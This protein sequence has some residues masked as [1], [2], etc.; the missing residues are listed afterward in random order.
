MGV[1]FI[2]YRRGQRDAIAQA[3]PFQSAVRVVFPDTNQP[4]SHQSSD[5]K[6]RVWSQAL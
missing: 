2:S 5:L 3:S 4:H 6:V 1:E